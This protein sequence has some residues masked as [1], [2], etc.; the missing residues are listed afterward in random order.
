MKNGDVDKDQQLDLGQWIDDRLATRLPDGEWQPNVAR[1]L[2]RN[3]EMQNGHADRGIRTQW[4]HTGQRW[5]GPVANKYVD[6]RGSD[7]GGRA[8]AYNAR[9]REDAQ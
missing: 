5:R 9:I 7:L 1:G 2:A 8:I 4:A 3:N 6:A